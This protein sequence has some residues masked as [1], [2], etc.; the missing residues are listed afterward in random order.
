MDAFF[1]WPW[2]F[3]PAT[4]IAFSG[5][6]LAVR[7]IRRQLMARRL[8]RVTM[9]KPIGLVSGF[10]LFLLGAPLVVAAAGWA[11]QQPWLFWLGVIIAGEETLETTMLL[12]ALREGERAQALLARR[13]PHIA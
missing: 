6:W 4:A 13:R 1:E 11:F 5:M 3:Y 10:R 8:A 2:R 9:A 12:A 7:G